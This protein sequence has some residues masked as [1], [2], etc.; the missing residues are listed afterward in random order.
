M[1]FWYYGDKL[2]PGWKTRTVLMP[3]EDYDA[4]EEVSEKVNV[5][6]S[7]LM[8]LF[9]RDGI[10]RFKKGELPVLGKDRE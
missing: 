10:A 4:L 9:M 2:R 1:L 5:D 7:T 3:P 8:R 6:R